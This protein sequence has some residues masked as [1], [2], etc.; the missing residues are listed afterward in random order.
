VGSYAF[1]F[2]GTPGARNWPPAKAF[3]TPEHTWHNRAVNP[4]LNVLTKQWTISE[5]QM[6]SLG[7]IENLLKFEVRNLKAIFV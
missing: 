7:I 1:R 3:E 6:P 4:S 2:R 5:Y